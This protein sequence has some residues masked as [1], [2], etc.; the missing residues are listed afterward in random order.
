M[1]RSIATSRTGDSFLTRLLD[2]EMSGA[3]DNQLEFI[4]PGQRPPI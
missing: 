2:A 1:A 3:L 4:A